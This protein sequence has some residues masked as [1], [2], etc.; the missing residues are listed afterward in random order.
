MFE[1]LG[2][3]QGDPSSWTED[4]IEIMDDSYESG[5]AS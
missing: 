5:N 1:R 3:V 4:V 2:G